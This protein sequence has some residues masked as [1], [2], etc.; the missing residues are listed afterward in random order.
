MI[1]KDKNEEN[2]I[3]D[4]QSNQGFKVTEQKANETSTGLE[5]ITAASNKYSKKFALSDKWNRTSETRA[6]SKTRQE[7]AEMVKDQEQGTSVNTEHNTVFKL[8]PKF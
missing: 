5:E 6:G 3:A 2:K 8:G 4:S 7:D 1:E